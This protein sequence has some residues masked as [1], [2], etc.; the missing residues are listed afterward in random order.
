MKERAEKLEYWREREKKF[1]EKKK[2]A[3]ELT[4]RKSSMWIDEVEL[5]KKLLENFVET[6]SVY[7]RIPEK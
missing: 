3:K 2:A 6:T 5:E 1:E 4:R 7:G